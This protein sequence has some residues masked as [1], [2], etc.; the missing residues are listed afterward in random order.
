MPRGIDHVIH[1]VRDLD[2]AAATYEKLGFL[3]SSR[4]KHPFVT[5]N[6]IAQLDGSYIEIPRISI[7]TFSRRTA[8]A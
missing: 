7:A 8:R 1:L 6:R 5:H 4:N 3:V 2:A